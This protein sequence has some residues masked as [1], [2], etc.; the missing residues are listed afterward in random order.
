MQNRVVQ[1]TC[2]RKL[3]QRPVT[4]VTCYT[5]LLLNWQHVLECNK[6]VTLLSKLLLGRREMLPEDDLL[7]LT[8]IGQS[9]VPI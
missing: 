5:A 2:G 9:S 6:V 4:S 1:E 8:Q 3:H 7:S